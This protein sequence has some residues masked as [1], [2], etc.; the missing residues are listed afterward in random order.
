MRPL[1][2]AAVEK[3]KVYDFPGNIRELRN[4]IERALILSTG[5]EIG[6][7]DFP[8]ALSS[9]GSPDAD[10]AAL[11]WLAAMPE[12]V[13]LRDLLE[14]TEKTLISRALK[15][16]SGVQAEAARRLQLSRSDLAYK[17]TKYGMRTDSEEE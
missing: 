5:S 12:T 2:V 1:S 14:Q 16:A 15:S 4:L 13:N 11:D 17:L 6:P 3:L 10:A 9:G 8:L 7:H